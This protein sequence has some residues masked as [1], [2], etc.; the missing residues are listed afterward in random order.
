[1]K[2]EFVKQ[3]VCEYCGKKFT[4]EKECKQHEEREQFQEFMDNQYYREE[5]RRRGR[6]W[7]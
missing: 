4:N 2:V 6:L 5:E 7:F 3:Y 1:M